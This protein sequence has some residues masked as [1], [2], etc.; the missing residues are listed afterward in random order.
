MVGEI[1]ASFQRLP[2]WVRIWMVV[3]LAPVNFAPLFF[4]GTH[5]S[6]IW[7]AALSV[8]GMVFNMPILLRQRGFSAALAFPHL[9]FWAPLVVMLL[10]RPAP[11]DGVNGG[12]ATLLIVILVVDVISLAFDSVEAVKWVKGD[13]TIA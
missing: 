12:Y 11:F 10:L 13:R 2:L 1:W 4:L 6:A 9:V 5:P 3:I 7:V 8:A